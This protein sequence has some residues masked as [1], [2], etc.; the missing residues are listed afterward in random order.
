[1]Q[2]SRIETAKPKTR[3]FLVYGDSG[4]GKSNFIRSLQGVDENGI[5]PE[6]GGLG[7]SMTICPGKI[8]T[9]KVLLYQRHQ[10]LRRNNPTDRYSWDN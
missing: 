1:M 9:A 7:E 3:S 4:M 6:V 8:Y 5:P 10:A 2:D